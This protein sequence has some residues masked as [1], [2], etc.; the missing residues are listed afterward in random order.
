VTAFYSLLAIRYSALAVRNR[1]IASNL[2][3]RKQFLATIAAKRSRK[4]P[5]AAMNSYQILIFS[6]EDAP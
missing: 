5:D 1:P 4:H 2:N 6:R 3:D